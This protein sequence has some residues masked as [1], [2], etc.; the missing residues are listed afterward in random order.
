MQGDNNNGKDAGFDKLYASGGGGAAIRDLGQVSA[1]S[2]TNITKNETQGGAGSNGK[3]IL[4]WY[5]QGV[6]TGL[7][8]CFGTQ[9]AKDC[10]PGFWV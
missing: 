2:Q 10:L 3:I 6:Q 1:A 9:C 4:E 5:E 8:A 7:R